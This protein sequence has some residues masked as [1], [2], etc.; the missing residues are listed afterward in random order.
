MTIDLPLL[1]FTT[2]NPARDTVWGHDDA[3]RKWSPRRSA[4]F[5]FGSC[6]MF[7]LTLGMT[8]ARLLAR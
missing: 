4:A 8:T 2:R 6:G 3:D 1:R 5:V 7:W